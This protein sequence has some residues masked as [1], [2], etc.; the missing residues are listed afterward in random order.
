MSPFTAIN[1]YSFA[2]L[3]GLNKSCD[4]QKVMWHLASL[5]AD[6][7]QHAIY[8][9]GNPVT[10]YDLR[11]DTVSL[12]PGN[13]I[14]ALMAPHKSGII[15][16]LIFTICYIIISRSERFKRG[17]HGVPFEVTSRQLYYFY[18]SCI[19]INHG[20]L[21]ATFTVLNQMNHD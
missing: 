7:D 1:G 19:F 9:R 4:G 6:T 16:S 10:L 12:T 18:T 14:T 2:N 15:V 20:K 13:S 11:T 21:S 17:G 8:F 5:G 3:P